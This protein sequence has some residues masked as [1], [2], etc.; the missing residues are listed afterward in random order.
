MKGL[1]RYCRDN[2][3]D[4]FNPIAMIALAIAFFAGCFASG[5]FLFLILNDFVHFL[6][7]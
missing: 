2:P 4:F 6:A 5:W 7:S 3:E 1:T